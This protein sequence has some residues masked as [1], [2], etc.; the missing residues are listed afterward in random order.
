MMD[1]N[2]NPAPAPRKGRWRTVVFIA[3]LALNLVVIGL[4]AGAFFAG[5]HSYIPHH[6]DRV[7]MGLGDYIRALPE[8]A[9]DRVLQAGGGFDRANL[10]ERLRELRRNRDALRQVME[11]E[12]FDIEAARAA[13]EAHRDKAL[14]STRA[15]QDAFLE[16]FAALS[17]EDRA[18]VIAE[19]RDARKHRKSKWRRKD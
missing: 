10:R 6:L 1:T 11:A 12:P 8:E 5:R 3:S 19:A 13:L 9:R 7:S 2:P 4:V 16:A 14:Q 17:P 18:A 15:V